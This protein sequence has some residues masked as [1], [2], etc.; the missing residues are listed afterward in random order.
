MASSTPGNLVAK[1]PKGL[2]LLSDLHTE[3]GID[4]PI[5]TVRSLA[6][7]NPELKV[8]A[9]AGDLGNWSV[10]NTESS[11]A[12][13]LRRISEEFPFKILVVPGNH[14]YYFCDATEALTKDED[15]TDFFV[16]ADECMEEMVKEHGG[17]FLQKNVEVVGKAVIAGTTLWSPS[18][19]ASKESIEHMTDYLAID[20]F[21]PAICQAIHEDQAAWLKSM[22]TDPEIAPSIVLTHH[23]PLDH[24]K[25][26]H[27]AYTSES[28]SLFHADLSLLF[29]DPAFCSPRFWG[30]G[31]THVRKAV[32]FGK[33]LLMANALGDTYGDHLWDLPSLTTPLFI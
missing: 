11:F 3:H 30:F 27:R 19:S 14:D 6:K 9:L 33:T 1:P 8:L 29:G 26:R 4:R 16:L 17:I 22:T 5:R 32:Y 7:K 25:L 31:H 13:F 21:T 10:E 20:G 18:L 15:P 23:P 24:P 2:A 12:T 28:A